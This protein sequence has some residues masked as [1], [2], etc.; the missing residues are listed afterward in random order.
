M[1]SL[2]LH[3]R[4]GLRNAFQELLL[5]FIC[6]VTSTLTWSLFPNKRDGITLVLLITNTSPGFKIEGRSLN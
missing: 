1:V 3:F 5:V 4:P 2:T 6:K